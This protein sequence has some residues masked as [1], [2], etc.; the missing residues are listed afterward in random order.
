MMLSEIRRHIDIAATPL[1]MAGICGVLLVSPAKSQVDH[2]AVERF[3]KSGK[4]YSLAKEN[5]ATEKYFLLARRGISS[6]D[7]LYSD[8]TIRTVKEVPGAYAISESEF[9]ATCSS[10]NPISVSI[11][12]DP[13]KKQTAVNPSLKSPP[14]GQK[15]SYNL[16]WAACKNQ[17]K[18]FR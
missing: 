17:F 4:L 6:E 12:S 18:K 9:S 2:K 1:A 10:D 16:W 11:G 14:R 7:G 15:H 13:Q 5:T 8:G 3:G